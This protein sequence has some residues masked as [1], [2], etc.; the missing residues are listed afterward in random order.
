MIWELDL[1]IVIPE[2]F[3]LTTDSLEDTSETLE[4]GLLYFLPRSGGG[5]IREKGRIK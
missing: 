3:I 2:N 4:C 5:S 1:D